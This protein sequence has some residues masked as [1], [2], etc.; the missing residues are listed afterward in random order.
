MKNKLSNFYIFTGTELGI[1]KIYLDQISKVLKLPIVRADSVMSIHSV[2][3]TR[4][5]FGA[6]NSI[7]VIRDDKDIMK[8]EEVYKTVISNLL[9]LR[10]QLARKCFLVFLAFC[11]L[12]LIFLHFVHLP[13]CIVLK[14]ECLSNIALQVYSFVQTLLISNTHLSYSCCLFI[15]NLPTLFKYLVVAIIPLQ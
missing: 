10:F 5:L 9:L 3:T 14:Y 11:L 4:S 13:K 8:H 2:C 1:Q 6:T 15:P 7:Y 12:F